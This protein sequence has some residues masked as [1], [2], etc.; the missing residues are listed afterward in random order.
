MKNK[1]S[2]VFL[3]V[4]LTL[5]STSFGAQKFF[6]VSKVGTLVYQTF[7]SLALAQTTA[8]QATSGFKKK[9]PDSIKLKLSIG[10]HIS[11]KEMHSQN[12]LLQSNKQ[13]TVKLG[14]APL[15]TYQAII[16]LQPL[17]VNDAVS[18]YTLEMNIVDSKK[19][20]VAYASTIIQDFPISL[21]TLLVL[22]AAKPQILNISLS[23]FN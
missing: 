7:G 2:F 8:S 1:I 14:Y 15:N 10:E 12:V 18:G 6:A 5:S 20:S 16:N 4:V 21:S 3:L 19:I 9:M 11:K 17:T 13:T 22:N 23:A